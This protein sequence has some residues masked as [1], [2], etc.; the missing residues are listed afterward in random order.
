MVQAGTI[1][2]WLVFI[3]IFIPYAVLT[4]NLN[5]AKFDGNGA[6][7]QRIIRYVYLNFGHILNRRRL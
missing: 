1:K 7:D 6:T 5:V 4:Q 2:R 3:W